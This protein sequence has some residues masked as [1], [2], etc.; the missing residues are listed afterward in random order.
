MPR[1]FY[2]KPHSIDFDE[3]KFLFVCTL[4]NLFWTEKEKKPN[5]N[6]QLHVCSGRP[7]LCFSF[8]LVLRY[9]RYQEPKIAGIWLGLKAAEFEEFCLVENGKF[10]NT[11]KCQ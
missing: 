10:M 3:S 7:F 6:P 2:L 1:N 5:P 8:S 11:D 9:Q 4:G